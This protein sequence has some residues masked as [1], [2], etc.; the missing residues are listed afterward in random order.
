MKNNET[1]TWIVIAIA[2][3]VVFSG[4]GTMRFGGGYGGMMGMMY[5]SYGGGMM[6]FGWLYGILVLIALVLFIIWIVKQLQNPRR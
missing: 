4:F 1:I 2:V 3:I 5:G 6:F